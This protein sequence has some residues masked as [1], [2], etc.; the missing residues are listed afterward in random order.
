MKHA[1]T[2]RLVQVLA[3][4]IMSL[5]LV[6]VAHARITT[7]FSAGYWNVVEGTT[8]KNLL[9]C[10]ITTQ[11]RS[12]SW[13]F[14]IDFF[15]HAP[16]LQVELI[17][18]SWQIPENTKIPVIL[19]I[20]SSRLYTATATGDKHQVYWFIPKHL[21]GQFSYYFAKSNNMTVIFKNGNE[22]PWQLNL[23]G[24]FAAVRQFVRCMRAIN[25][26]QSGLSP[27]QPTQPYNGAP[28]QPFA[29]PS[30]RPFQPQPTPSIPRNENTSPAGDSPSYQHV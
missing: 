21:V 13:I 12:G 19:Q 16:V 9:M 15:P 7:V 4:T 11:N 22:P 24:S 27:V 26:A 3:A 17:K 14:S 1:K 23:T 8:A 20:G 29:S 28:T 2:R 25:A 10:G 30:P 5:G 18:D 6:G